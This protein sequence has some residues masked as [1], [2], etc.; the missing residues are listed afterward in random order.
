[1]QARSAR[2]WSHSFYDGRCSLVGRESGAPRS[3]EAVLRDLD[4]HALRRTLHLLARSAA[5]AGDVGDRSAAAAVARAKAAAQTAER[6]AA[7]LNA[8]AKSQLMV[9]NVSF[10]LPLHFTRIVLTV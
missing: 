5:A 6:L 10:V 2:A 4:E 1:M 9:D 3:A 8:L 7:Q